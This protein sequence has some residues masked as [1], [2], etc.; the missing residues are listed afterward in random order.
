M[1]QV[2]SRSPAPMPAVDYAALSTYC[3]EGKLIMKIHKTKLS[4]AVSSMWT[5]TQM[6]QVVIFYFAR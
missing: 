3:Y 5:L 2:L 4:A 6:A 1:P